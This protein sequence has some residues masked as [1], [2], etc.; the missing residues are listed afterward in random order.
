MTV[1]NLSVLV[2][3]IVIYE[4][5]L[6]ATTNVTSLNFKTL[7]FTYSGGSHVPVDILLLYLHALVVVAVVV[8]IHL[9][10]VCRHFICL[11]SLSQGHVA[12]RN[13]P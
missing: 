6:G 5:L 9:C 10:V 3:Y 1:V 13:L 12:C 4:A 2:G 11:M 8:S 7:H